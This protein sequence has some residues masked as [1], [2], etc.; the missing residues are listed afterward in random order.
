MMKG[1]Q[2]LPEID[3]IPTERHVSDTSDTNENVMQYIDRRYN[4]RFNKE[5]GQPQHKKVNQ[6]TDS[7]CFKLY[8]QLIENMERHILFLEEELVRKDKII[9][10]LIDKNCIHTTNQKDFVGGKNFHKTDNSFHTNLNHNKHN[11]YD[12]FSQPSQRLSKKTNNSDNRKTNE[13]NDN[14]IVSGEIDNNNFNN[15]EESA[16]DAFK[17]V[18]YRKS[19]R[20]NKNKQKRCVSVIGDSIVKEIKGHLLTSKNEKVVVKSFP[21]ATIK[22]MYDYANPTLEMKPDTLIIHV[23]TNDLRNMED[24][25]QVA[26]NI[27]DLA[28]HRNR[29]N[30]IPVIISSLTCRE[31]RYKERIKKVNDDLK[32]KCEQR[33]IGYLDNSNINRYHLNRSKLHLNSKGSALMAKNFRNIISK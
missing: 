14:K 20:T 32:A 25:K 21:G 24:D 29:E 9:E 8:D 19:N 11:S 16:V 26:D 28:T 2:T 23:G 10:K 3:D 6:N 4:E 7:S 1:G 33:N 17:N 27:I 13:S 22:Q 30:E 31:D 18:T 12:V 15:N 5:D